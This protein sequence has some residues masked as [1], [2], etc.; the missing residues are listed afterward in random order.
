MLMKPKRETIRTDLLI[1]GGGAAGCMA[2]IGAKEQGDLGRHLFSKRRRF[3]EAATSVR[4]TTIC[5][6]I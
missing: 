5:W 4:A 1:I 3:Q 6:P 2:A